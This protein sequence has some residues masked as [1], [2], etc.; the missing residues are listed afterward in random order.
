MKIT[1]DFAYIAQIDV[2]F[3]NSKFVEMMQKHYELKQSTAVDKAAGKK[4]AKPK[5]RPNCKYYFET[6][7]A[8]YRAGL[9]HHEK[10]EK[11]KV[12]VKSI[13]S[14]AEK[15]EMK[16]KIAELTHAIDGLKSI[17][18]P[19]FA[20][21]HRAYRPKGALRI[22]GAFVDKY[23]DNITSKVPEGEVLRVVTVEDAFQHLTKRWTENVS[24]HPSVN[25][26]TLYNLFNQKIY[27]GITTDMCKAYINAIMKSVSLLA[28]EEDDSSSSEEEQQPGGDNDDNSVG[29]DTN[30][31]PSTEESASSLIVLAD[32]KKVNVV[33][34]EEEGVSTKGV[35]HA[36]AGSVGHEA[37]ME[38]RDCTLATSPV[39][40]GKGKFD[41]GTAKNDI[42]DCNEA[43]NN[44]GSVVDKPICE[45]NFP[46][47]MLNLV[48]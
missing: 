12:Q 41:S 36:S 2:G 39:V 38:E 46:R 26:Q 47:K 48:H 37:V 20:K 45:K 32:G 15:V 25:H 23:K 9:V 4:N 34:M 22:H 42:V 17:Y 1:I 13:C 44:V 5:A 18:F 43:S 8:E 28:P 14:K 27:Y 11:L 19:Y 31:P 10:R 24:T 30:L 35:A 33:G 29:S 3:A 40:L 16:K 21:N 6:Q 7:L